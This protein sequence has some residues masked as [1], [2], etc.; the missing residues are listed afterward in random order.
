MRLCLIHLDYPISMLDL[1]SQISQPA[2]MVTASHDAALPPSMADGMKNFVP[3][4]EMHHVE[5]SGHWIL[6]EKPAE[7]NQLLETFL[8]KIY[9]SS[10]L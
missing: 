9:N 10:K 6:W 1:D 7:C 4:L 5:G 2:M 3:K 8:A